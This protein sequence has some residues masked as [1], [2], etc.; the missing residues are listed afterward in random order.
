[1]R[2]RSVVPLCL[3]L[4]LPGPALAAPAAPRAPVAARVQRVFDAAAARLP[5]R[6]GMV[7]IELATEA[8]A[9][10][11]PDVVFEA[12]SLIKLGVLV[13]LMAQVDAGRVSLDERMTLRD[14]DRTGGS[15]QVRSMKP[16][17]RLRVGDLAD[18]MITGSDNTATD[19]LVRR[20]GMSA[21]DT[22]MQRMGWTRTRLRR[23]MMDFAAIDRGCDN[24]T[25]PADVASLLAA[26][27]RRRV[28]SPGACATMEAILLGQTRRHIIAAGLP[29]GTRVA[30]KTG[31][32]DGVIH[33]AA[34]VRC[35]SSS[36]GHAGSTDRAYVLVL[37]SDRV[38]D[39]DEVRRVF[40]EVSNAV[41]PI[42]R[43]R[44]SAKR[45]FAAPVGARIHKEATP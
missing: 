23:R 44:A 43:S 42:V 17:T 37:M 26:I 32:L 6:T 10:V 41:Y 1:M 18:K 14:E 25:S 15:G 19:M 30:S 45:P 31:E 8:R 11:R 2:F 16:G 22:K 28:V 13:E 27:A 7:F 39:T 9:A 3:L 29:K 4:T 20:L 40:R 5:G 12:A 35:S 34:I 33:D 38:T 24:V 21:I 36:N